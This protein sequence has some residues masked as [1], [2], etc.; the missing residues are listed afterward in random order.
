MGG[1]IKFNAQTVLKIIRITR[2]QGIANMKKI[3]DIAKRLF[4]LR[5]L[6]PALVIT[7]A[8]IGSL[9]IT[10]FGLKFND[11]QVILALL[12]FLAIDA[13][14]ERLDILTN[15]ENN[16]KDIQRSVSS[17]F[18]ASEF[19]KKRSDLP[20]MEQLIE[21]AKDEVWI[22]GVSLGTMVNIHWVFADKIK[23]GCK[24][25]FLVF[26][27]DGQAHL[28]AAKYYNW[29]S[30]DD[31]LRLIK[32]NLSTLARIPT[33]GQDT[34]LQ[35]RVIDQVLSSGFF[36]V[37]PNKDNARMIVQLYM[38]HTDSLTSPLFELTKKD[39]PAWFAVFLDQFQTVWDNASQFAKVE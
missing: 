23:Q 22:S 33:Q 30:P 17:K 34:R 11:Q 37:D 31:I 12:G 24:I 1:A 3:Q 14:V 10:P 35:I 13:L 29:K 28:Q 26:D 2:E 8:V 32:H 21:S 25:R 9:G 5:N 27:P 20:R 36:I 18:K 16:V 6:V 38:Y 7:G 39:D 19:L 4:S 15:I